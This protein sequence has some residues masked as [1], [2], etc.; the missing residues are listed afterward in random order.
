MHG[1]LVNVRC[2]RSPDGGHRGSDAVGGE[3]VE[4]GARLPEVEHGGRPPD[5]TSTEQAREDRIVGGRGI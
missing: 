5:R 3:A 2:T 1:E 4:M